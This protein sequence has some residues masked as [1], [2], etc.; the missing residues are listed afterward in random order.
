M[1][2]K[3][4]SLKETFDLAVQ[5]HKEKNYKV[6]EYLYSK[7][8]ISKPNH[9]QTLM[10]IGTLCTET[11][12]YESAIKY[13]EKAI[14]LQ[15]QNALAY[16][17]IGMIHGELGNFTNAIVCLKNAM[18]INPELTDTRNN[19]CI[20]LRSLTP[21]QLNE[22]EVKDLKELFLILYKRNDIDHDDIFRNAKNILFRSENYKEILKLDN[23]SS[24]LE[25]ISVQNLLNEDLLHLMMQKSLISDASIELF[26]IKIRKEMLKKIY[27]GN[28][29][30]I[31]VYSNFL[32]SL[33]EQCFFNEFIYFQTEE[34]IY[35]IKKILSNVESNKE[36][37]EIEIA[38]L[39]SYISLTSSQKLEEKVIS[40]KS[41]NTLFNDLI[42]IHVYDGKKEQDLK[43]TIKVNVIKDE[44]SQKVRKQYEE[45]PYPRWRFI[46]RNTKKNF[47]V[48]L[49]NQIKPNVIDIKSSEKF[50]NP[51]VLVA[52]CGT[53]RHISI[54]DS[55][56]N[57]NILAVDLSLSSLAYARRKAEENNLKNVSFLQSDILDLR[58]IKKK[59]DI[60]ESVGVIH[61]MKDPLKG[62]E[63]L[64][65]L[66]EPNGFLKLG[67]YSKIARQ[68]ISRARD[69]IKKNDLKTN[70]E[71]IRKCRKMILSEKNDNLLKK[72]S[73]GRDFYSM[74][75]VR[76]LIFHEQEYCFTIP[77][78]SQIMK[79]FKLNFLGF[80]DPIIKKKYYQI[81]NEDKNNLFENWDKFEKNNPEIFNGMYNFWVKK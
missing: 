79:K 64:L 29:K 60:I 69:F 30:E 59:F 16:N 74:S 54:V 27:E 81:Y 67:L 40:F 33:G 53:G 50:N 43:K 58:N 45:N 13:F 25:N 11:K 52:G 68:H 22:K 24:L 36:N 47:L 19:L 77:E 41:S 1:L 44:I 49:Q 3:N 63:V 23:V 31:N 73:V 15:P 56:E 12:N 7:L 21:N 18:M 26:L 51:N 78:I 17:N 10:L 20:L 35:Q 5:N 46:Y 48:R 6:A 65:D 32:L 80:S 39:G 76:D 61:H 42:K 8:L 66:L 37:S 38:I 4:L 34:E 9:I 57:A 72:V 70:V 28:L 14:K 55:Y 2:E 75:S 71:D 62:L